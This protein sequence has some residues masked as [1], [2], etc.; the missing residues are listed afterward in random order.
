MN[1]ENYEVGQKIIT[2][3]QQQ[4]KKIA[5]AESVTGGQIAS[6]ITCISGASKVFMG[7]VVCYSE[8]AKIHSAGVDVRDLR[9]Y[10]VYSEKIA[11]Q[12]AERILKRNI[13]D[14]AIATTGCAEGDCESAG[15]QIETGEVIF[16][17]AQKNAP[18]QIFREKFSGTR[19]QVQS[20]A[21]EFA[22]QKVLC[23]LEIC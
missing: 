20:S 22:L 4:K 13:A 8:H 17:L 1:T 5:S 3:L 15:I 2:L 7:G 14:I 10:G 16:A 23:A 6:C 9:E 21:T 19:V 18:T 11:E 12:M